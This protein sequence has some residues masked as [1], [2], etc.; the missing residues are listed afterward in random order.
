MCTAAALNLLHLPMQASHACP[1]LTWD[2]ELGGALLH[3]H[4]TSCMDPHREA[5][6]REE[7]REG[8]AWQLLSERTDVYDEEDEDEDSGGYGGGRG[9]AAAAAEALLEEHGEEQQGGPPHL[10]W[11]KVIELLL[12]LRRP[13]QGPPPE[14]QVEPGR[15]GVNSP[16]NGRGQAGSDTAAATAERHAAWVRQLQARAAA[17]A[18]ST[19]GGTAAAGGAATAAG[20][21]P[22]AAPAPAQAHVPQPAPVKEEVQEGSAQPG[23][24][25]VTAQEAGG[26]GAAVRAHSLRVKREQEQEAR[27]AQGRSRLKR[28][29]LQEPGGPP[30]SQQHQGGVKEEQRGVKAEQQQMKQEGG[31]EGQHRLQ[32]GDG[33]GQPFDDAGLPMLALVRALADQWVE[34]FCSWKDVSSDM[35]R[36]L[37]QSYP[38]CRRQA[39][40]YGPELIKTMFKVLHV[41]GMHTSIDRCG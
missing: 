15:A 26:A 10:A 2:G 31:G 39:A 25:E 18:A 36:D 22:V 32:Q 13:E 9:G 24:A 14:P 28:M 34:G 40:A 12:G 3:A 11:L 37:F 27:P 30:G 17:A 35:L 19:G 16:G 29:R 23:P 20:A 41:L 38:Q 7:I 21:A 6:T 1:A 8:D 33:P 5:R 4:R